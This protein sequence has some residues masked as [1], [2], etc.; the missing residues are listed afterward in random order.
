MHEAGV[1]AAEQ[2][3][4]QLTCRLNIGDIGVVVVLIIVNN[5]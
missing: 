3:W 5:K 4:K 1:E 2:V